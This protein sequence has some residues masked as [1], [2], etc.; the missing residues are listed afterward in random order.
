[1]PYVYQ[2]VALYPEIKIKVKLFG[3]CV[4]GLV[5]CQYSHSYISPEYCY[6]TVIFVTVLL[7]HARN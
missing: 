4:L 3:P 5:V 6:G 7:P 2:P 1:M